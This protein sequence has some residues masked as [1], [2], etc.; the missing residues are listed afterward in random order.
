MSV[1]AKAVRPGGIEPPT[2]G[3]WVRRRPYHL[4]R[5]DDVRSS[6]P[7]VSTIGPDPN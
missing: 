1:R 2:D 5:A 6:W 3:L 7:A 4:V